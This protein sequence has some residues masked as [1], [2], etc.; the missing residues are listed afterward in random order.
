MKRQTKQ[1][2]VP[3]NT[4]IQAT[5]VTAEVMAVGDRARATKTVASGAICQ[6]LPPLV[7]GLRAALDHLSLQPPARQAIEEDVA[8]LDKAAATKEHNSEHVR[9]VL[10]SIA[11]KLKTVGVIVAQAVEIAE[12]VK[13]IAGLFGLPL[14]W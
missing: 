8:K 4:G 3:A 5:N 1:R 10:E 7:A 2:Q 13:R 9:G 12:P 14:P 11:G 6:E